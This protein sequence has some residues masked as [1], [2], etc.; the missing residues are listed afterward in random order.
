MG[1]SVIPHA[2]CSSLS[3]FPLFLCFFLPSFLSS[4]PLPLSPGLEPRAS[5]AELYSVLINGFTVT[6][7]F[8]VVQDDTLAHEYYEM[9]NSIHLG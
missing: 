6:D 4:F 8:Y 5:T 3:F 2:V 7:N 9:I 1:I